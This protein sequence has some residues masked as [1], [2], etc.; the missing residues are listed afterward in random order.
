[1]LIL[2]DNILA[3]MIHQAKEYAPVEA[4][5]LLAGTDSTI[6]KHYE[7]T[8]VDASREHFSLDVR[9]QF[10]AAK[11]MRA[12]GLEMLAVYH[13]HPETPARMSQEDLRLALTPGIIY[14]IVSLAV[15]DRPDVK[16]FRVEN[17]Q[18]IE[19]RIMVQELDGCQ[20]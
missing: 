12:A 9:E 16:G 18:P 8:N 6:I 14:V 4:C 2:P 17:G 11:D 1:M 7:M 20:K 13:S 5:G 15:P 3:S 19:E 10:A